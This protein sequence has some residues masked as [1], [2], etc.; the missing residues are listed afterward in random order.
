MYWRG[1]DGEIAGTEPVSN[2]GSPSTDWDVGG[3]IIDREEI[4]VV[5][6]V[7]DSCW[8]AGT[9]YFHQ[10]GF[11]GRGYGEGSTAIIAAMRALVASKFGDEVPEVSP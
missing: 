7:S 1:G 2:L 8:V 5:R 3:P 6:G 10:G 4:S 11:T 9:Q